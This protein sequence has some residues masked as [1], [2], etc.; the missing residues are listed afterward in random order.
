MEMYNLLNDDEFETDSEEEEDS[1]MEDS[2]TQESQ[3]S[4]GQTRENL[5][6]SQS[7]I[8][9]ASANNQDDMKEKKNQMVQGFREE[10]EI[11]GSDKECLE[12]KPSTQSLDKYQQK[13][14]YLDET[15]N[16]VFTIQVRPAV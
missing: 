6:N 14:E 15:C 10:N 3:L 8:D 9:S 2:D 11:K 7:D 12:K 5:K 13:F 4:E 1:G 16:S